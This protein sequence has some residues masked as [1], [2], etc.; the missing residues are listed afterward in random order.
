MNDSSTS[1][2]LNAIEAAK[3]V[4]R[5]WAKGLPTDRYGSANELRLAAKG[6]GELLKSTDW[7]CDRVSALEHTVFK[8][9]EDAMQPHADPSRKEKDNG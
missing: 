5:R 7:L 6:I 1:I 2:D 8:R 3:E 4:H 9:G